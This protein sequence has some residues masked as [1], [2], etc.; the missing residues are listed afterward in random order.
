MGDWIEWVIWLNDVIR[1]FLLVLNAL[2]LAS[3][4]VIAMV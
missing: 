1:V 4:V 2:M 3:L